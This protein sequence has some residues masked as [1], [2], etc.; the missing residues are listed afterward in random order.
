MDELKGLTAL[1]IEPQAG[2]RGSLHGM[3]NQCGLSRIDDV[4]NASQAIRQL[5][6]H[7]YD[8]VLC[9]YELEGG[10]DGQQLLEDLRAQKLVKPTTLFF[11]VTG[12]GNFGK[13]VSAVEMLPTD[14]ILKP[15]TAERM[16][17]RVRRALARRNAML[18]V[19]Q[20]MELGDERGAIAACAAGLL[21]QPRYAT[22][23]ERQ[24]AELHLLLGEAAEAETIYANLYASKA[25]A[26]ARLGQA[27]ASFLRGDYIGAQGLLEELKKQ[28]RTF[29]EAYDW[30]ARTLQ[31]LGKPAQ[32]QAVLS[33]AVNI[34]PHAVRRL[35][36]LGDA[37]LE[38]GD[39]GTA[40]KALKQV[41]SKARHSEFRDPEDHARLVQALVRK[42]D[43]AQAAIVIR[44]LEK[45]M[46]GQKNSEACG[47]IASA[48]LHE[49]LGETTD[50][51]RALH[52]ALTASRGAEL[53]ARMKIELARSCLENGEEEGAAEVMR[54]VMRNA[55]NGA[56]MARAMAVFERAG[57]G[58]QALALAHQSRQ[59]VADM[60]ALGATRARE[61]DFAGAV[62]LMVDAV[63]RLP[64]NPQVLF[65]AA[66][67]VLKCLEQTGWDERLGQY[68][69]DFIG[70]VRRLDPLNPRLPA[71]A[72]LHQQILQK[73]N[74]RAGRLRL[75][76]NMV[77][78]ALAAQN[79]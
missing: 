50:L 23:F 1:L 62:A 32:A 21:R 57:R 42:G 36:A 16:L 65:N 19:Y 77:L 70:G 13:V 40:E 46:A 27:R 74:I 3:L 49:Y 54:D 11:M 7:S 26:W 64:D 48:M 78:A 9:E 14:Y 29:L 12:E 56:V 52:N 17:E 8:L 33:E 55:A 30:L 47:A 37:A 59:E 45:S 25:I 2:M 24:R 35:R 39:A 22:D 4:A 58:T 6:I 68:A 76:P 53:S 43:P 20:L 51:A 5:G 72:G 34:S 31:A 15:F 67:A 66:V 38:A 18:P 41:L 28:H 71:L 60:V 75:P 44:D 79:V 61:G 73:Y 69:L 63:T 10:Q